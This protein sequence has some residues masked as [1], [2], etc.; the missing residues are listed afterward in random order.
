[1]E[2]LTPKRLQ[3]PDNSHCRHDFIQFPRQSNALYISPSA[4]ILR[5]WNLEAYR[6]PLAL[7]LGNEG[8][9]SAIKI[10]RKQMFVSIHVTRFLKTPVTQKTFCLSSISHALLSFELCT[11]AIIIRST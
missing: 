5:E 4:T 10:T 2:R 8:C 1:M 6:A 3:R 11:S 7:I 9:F